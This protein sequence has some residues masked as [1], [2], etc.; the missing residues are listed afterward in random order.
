MKQYVI[1]KYTLKNKITQTS[2][3]KTT[4][5]SHVCRR[6]RSPFR[7]PSTAAWGLRLGG[8]RRRPSNTL[9]TNSKGKRGTKEECTQ[10]KSIVGVQ[11]FNFKN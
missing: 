7:A 5:P 8:L 6:L 3:R 10:Y 11:Y 4:T 2:R 9:S 1:Q